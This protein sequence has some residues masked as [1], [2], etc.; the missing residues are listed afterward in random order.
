MKWHLINKKV[1]ELKEWQR[2][3]R[4]LTDKGIKDLTASIKKFGIAEPIVINTNNTICGGHGRKKV[5]ETLKIKDV[6]CYVPNKKLTDKQMEELNIRLNK[7]IAGE[8]DFDMLAN[9]FEFDELIDWGFD[10]NELFGLDFG[11]GIDEEKLDDVPEVQKKAI[12]KTGDLF[13]LDGKH[14]ILCGDSTKK[15]DIEKLMDGSKADMVFTDPPY[16][17]MSESFGY[18]GNAKYGD[19]DSDKVFKFETWVPHLDFATKDDSNILIFEYWHN[20]VDLWNEMEK[21]FKIKNMIIW[22]ALNRFNHAN[23]RFINRYD[24]V[25]WGA[26]GKY[27][28]NQKGFQ[29]RVDDILGCRPNRLK[30]TGQE[31][32]LG[33]KPIGFLETYIKI[34]S[35]GGYI[36]LDLFGGSGSTLI[37]C[38]QT[39]RICYGMEIY[40]IYI[41]VILKRYKSLY[42]D[43]KI[44]CLNRKFNF[45]KLF[46]Q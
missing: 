4:R 38:K 25:L 41:D 6:A 1:S 26:K 2:N 10:E 11:D 13:L 33:T 39:R 19:L 44:E 31:K 23:R 43:S 42:P 18:K 45:S 3:P 9:L 22:H 8:F 37:A 5:L 24:I 30:D 15:I 17:L 28:F 16:R 7:N 46:T 14:R 20:V 27:Y 35:N 12:S 40:P 34:L 32:I 21:C 29:N 36:I